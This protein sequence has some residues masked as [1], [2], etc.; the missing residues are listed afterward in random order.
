MFLF[1]RI[2]YAMELSK[3]S[4]CTLVPFAWDSSLARELLQHP[5]PK[6]HHGVFENGADPSELFVFDGTGI[7]L[8]GLVVPHQ[9][10]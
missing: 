9:Y 6:R 7:H 8:D 3:T 10:G 1:G 4:K 2:L 5:R